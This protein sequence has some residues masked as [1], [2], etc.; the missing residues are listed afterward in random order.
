MQIGSCKIDTLMLE[1]SEGKLILSV[2]DSE[3]ISPNGWKVSAV[4]EESAK[5]EPLF[6]LSPK[7]FV[8]M[9][10]SKVTVRGQKQRTSE[11]SSPSQD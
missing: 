10:N 8:D 2:S 7:E 9:M 6:T 5:S 3:I 1:D 11:A 4:L